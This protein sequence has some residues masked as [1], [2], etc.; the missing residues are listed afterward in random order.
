M[1]LVT[2]PTK[3]VRVTLKIEDG[4]PDVYMPFDGV[5][6][7]QELPVQRRGRRYLVQELGGES[8][9]IGIGGSTERAVLDYLKNRLDVEGA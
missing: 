9:P 3:T 5:S 2:A 4:D 8:G 7:D 6:V 1:N